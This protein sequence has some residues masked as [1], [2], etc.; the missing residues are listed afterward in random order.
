M[1]KT[2]HTGDCSSPGLDMLSP[3]ACSCPDVEC[4]LHGRCCDCLSFHR[5]RFS[6]GSMVENGR[7]LGWLP[8][9]YLP[10]LKER[11]G[12]EPEKDWDI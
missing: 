6:A 9:C 11:Y 1:E 10:L 8:K 2:L 5:E 3:R 7:D 4:V 12:Y